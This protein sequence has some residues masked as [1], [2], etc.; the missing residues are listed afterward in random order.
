MK[1]QRKTAYTQRMQKIRLE[2]RGTELFR[3]KLHVLLYKMS[4]QEYDIENA[5]YKKMYKSEWYWNES[6][7]RYY[8]DPIEFEKYGYPDGLGGI[9]YDISPKAKRRMEERASGKIKS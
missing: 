3:K 4:E 8:I 9:E 6:R 1:R 7:R 5:P 2:V